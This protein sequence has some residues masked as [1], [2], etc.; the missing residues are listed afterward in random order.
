MDWSF[1]CPNGGVTVRREGEW[2]VC[3]AISPAHSDGLYKAWLIGERG[4]ALL[5]T[6]IP[7][8]GALRLRRRM[9]VSG[10]REKGAFPPVGAEIAMAY[11]LAPEEE[12]P[13]Q[14]Q[15]TDCPCRLLGDPALSRALQG[16]NRGLVKRDTDG[17]FLAIPYAPVCPFPIPPLFCLGQLAKLGSRWYAVFRFSRQGT[18]EVLHNFPGEGETES[19]T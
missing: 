6:L 2:A 9:A 16:V 13:G 7:E 5:G 3:Q 14:W 1:E 11:P 4:K 15:W 10:L 19:V 18:P 17:F 12:P 8:G